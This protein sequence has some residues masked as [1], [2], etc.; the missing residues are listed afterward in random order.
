MPFRTRT[1]VSGAVLAT[2]AVLLCPVA[3]VARPT[4]VPAAP[5]PSVA[6]APGDGTAPGTADRPYFY[7]EGAP[8]TV[9]SD[10][11]SLS[12]PTG[13]TVTV[14]LGSS[15]PGSWLTLA[16][17]E[18]K[19]PP[20]TRASVPFTVTVPRDAAPGDHPGALSATFVGPS[21]GGGKGSGTGGDKGSGEGVGKGSG[22]K[23][24]GPGKGGEAGGRDDVPVHLRVTG[25]ALSALS[26]EQVSVDGRGGRGGAAVIRYTLVNR[27]NTVLTP[28]LAV[29]ADGLFGPLLRRAPRTLPLALRPGRSVDLTEKWP[30]PPGLDAV[31]VRLTVTAGGGAHGS[32]T[33]T[34]TAVPWAAVAGPAVL[35]AAGG[36]GL[37]VLRRRRRGTGASGVR[38]A[39]SVPRTA[40][41]ARPS[42]GGRTDAAG[43][44]ASTGSGARS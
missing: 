10:R 31:D 43:Q 4:A 22:A 34:Y 21:P 6:P 16:S 38:R 9:M 40:G 14:R 24:G 27:G 17:T 44:L 36:G 41:D 33:A 15:T 35:L 20:H 42:E 3:A 8:G 25:A 39:E 12:N 1:A 2:A 23:G 11:L 19:V 7:L 29:H 5:G 32:A 37:A 28:R 13:R 30:D 26:V 18:V